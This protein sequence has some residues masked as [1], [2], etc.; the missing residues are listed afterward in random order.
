MPPHGHLEPQACGY[1]LSVPEPGD[2]HLDHIANPE[3]LASLFQVLSIVRASM[4]VAGD[5]GAFIF[6][7]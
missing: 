6:D 3:V 5:W 2:F 7:E 1:L 4:T